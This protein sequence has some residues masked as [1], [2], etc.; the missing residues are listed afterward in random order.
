MRP[1]AKLSSSEL[2]QSQAY[3]FGLSNYSGMTRRPTAGGHWLF[4]KGTH[5]KGAPWRPE[6]EGGSLSWRFAHVLTR[7]HTLPQHAHLK[8]TSFSSVCLWVPGNSESTK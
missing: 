4:C 5:L 1:H 2:T 6:G 8:T 3:E 7:L